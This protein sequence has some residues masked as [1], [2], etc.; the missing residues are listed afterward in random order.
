MNEELGGEIGPMYGRDNHGKIS[1]P[2]GPG[3][4][5]TVPKAVV[6]AHERFL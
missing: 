1:V 2:P 5:G 6:R 4:M 3:Y